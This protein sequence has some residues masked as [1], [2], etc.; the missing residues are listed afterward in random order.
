LVLRPGDD[1]GRLDAELTV[2]EAAGAVGGGMGDKRLEVGL[3]GTA[4]LATGIT[5]GARGRP[6]T[7]ARQANGRGR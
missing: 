4:A 7:D 3:D 5:S 2:P 1:R 6:G